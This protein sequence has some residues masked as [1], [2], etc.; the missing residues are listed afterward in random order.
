MVRYRKELFIGCYADPDALP[1]FG[2]LPALLETELRE[3]ATHDVA[4]REHPHPRTSPAQARQL[5]PPGTNH[6]RRSAA[7]FLAS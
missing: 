7:T 6:D 1:E 3:L 4:R 5:N 2:L